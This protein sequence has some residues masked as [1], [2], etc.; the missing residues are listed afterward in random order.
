[1]GE[2]HDCL[3]I[4]KLYLFISIITGILDTAIVERGRNVVSCGRDGTARLWDV[5]EQTCLGVFSDSGGMVNCCDLGVPSESCG[6]LEQHLS[7][8]SKSGV[9]LS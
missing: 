3:Y 2:N 5:G 4:S 8:P 9:Y 6:S 7:P 1:M